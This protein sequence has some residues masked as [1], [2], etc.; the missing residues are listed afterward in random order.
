M[1]KQNKCGSQPEVT[2]D[3]PD[4]S[5]PKFPLASTIITVATAEVDL[6]KMTKDSKEN[7]SVGD[8]G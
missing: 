1:F 6:I 7:A 3:M 2:D 8:Q 4:S 5:N